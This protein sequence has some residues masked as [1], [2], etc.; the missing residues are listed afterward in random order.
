MQ[1]IADFNTSRYFYQNYYSHYRTLKASIGSA[2]NTVMKRILVPTDF[3][4]CADNAINFAIQAAKFLPSKILL[5]HAF[6]LNGDVY[7]DYMG[8]NKAYNQ[9]QLREATEKL[10]QLKMSVENKE[11]VALDTMVFTGGVKESILHFEN[12]K[13]IEL[14]VM[15]TSGASGFMQKIWGSKTAAVIGKTTVPVIAVPL[16]YQ[17]KKP[18]K[19]LLATNH[20]ETD[21]EMLD[22]IFELAESFKAK[23]QIVVFTNE[24]SDTALTYLEHA[25]KIPYYKEWLK[26]K[27]KDESIVIIHL[28]GI[29]FEHAL[30]NFISQNEIDLLAMVTYKRS[31]ADKIFHPGITKRMSYHTKIPLLAIPAK[32]NQV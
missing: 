23:V 20:F 8:V 24:A 21:L 19:I 5:V 1:I 22:I 16:E 7:T 29:N 10:G 27:Y 30:E 18:E 15:G 11:A 6:E 12:E 32:Q 25:R 26:E 3:S 17:W 31:F 2:K 28:F 14:V 4:A 13:D 9:S